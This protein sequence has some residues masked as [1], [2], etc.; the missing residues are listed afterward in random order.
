MPPL[1]YD[2]TQTDVLND[3]GY[4][5]DSE[6]IAMDPIINDLTSQ[7]KATAQ[8]KQ[9]PSQNGEQSRS[10]QRATNMDILMEGMKKELKNH[11]DTQ[12]ALV[13]KRCAEEVLKMLNKNS[14]TYKPAE[15]S[16]SDKGGDEEEND[17]IHNDDSFRKEFMYKTS[18]DKIDAL[19]SNLTNNSD[20]ALRDDPFA[21]DKYVTPAKHNGV[22]ETGDNVYV[23]LDNLNITEGLFEEHEVG[24]SSTVPSPQEIEVD[25]LYVKTIS[26]IPKQAV[27][28]VYKNELG[29]TLSAQRL[30]V[31]LT[32]EW[33]S[34]DIGQISIDIQEKKRTSDLDYP[35]VEEW[36]IKS[37]DIPKQ[38]DINSCGL[39]VLQCMEHWD[40][41][42]LTS[43]VS[44]T[45]VDESRE[46]TVASIVFSPTNILEKQSSPIPLA[47][48]PP[49]AIM[50]CDD[51]D[52]QESPD[53]AVLF[54]AEIAA[55]RAVLGACLPMVNVLA[56]LARCSGNTERAIN[57]LLDGDADPAR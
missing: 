23:T 37:Y 57:A 47:S 30:N 27:K 40:G 24:E 3:V 12:L 15:G 36:P 54:A 11:I 33:L 25:V 50:T 46:T 21:E 38:K 43:P 44:Q 7:P 53:Q 9:N 10:K 19:I 22:Q 32:H 28:G 5:R 8:T 42:R 20:A 18:S 26:K 55:A 52:W 16:E 49:D 31:V 17:S 13:P 39:W 41:N 14:V 6:I 51:D 45:R 34:D 1:I 35:D 29:A 56:A 2:C 4:E 48:A